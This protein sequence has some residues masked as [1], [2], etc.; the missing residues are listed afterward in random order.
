MQALGYVRISKN[1]KYTVSKTEFSLDEFGSISLGLV[2]ISK[3]TK[4]AV[5]KTEGV[6]GELCRLLVMLGN[7]KMYRFK[8]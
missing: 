8:N 2:R 1:T 3:N 7:P 4:C 6:L 5:S